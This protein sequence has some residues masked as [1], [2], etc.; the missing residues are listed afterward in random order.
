MI[1]PTS[2]LLHTVNSVSATRL[3]YIERPLTMQQARLAGRTVMEPDL[4]LNDF[5]CS[6]VI[7]W[8]EILVALDRPTQFQW[9][10]SAMGLVD[11]RK[12]FVKDI[13]DPVAPVKTLF[14][15]KIQEP[16]M[17]R[18]RS[19]LNAIE[20]RFGLAQAPILMAVEISIDF[21]PKA[22][23]DE[24]RR[25]LMGVLV[26]HHFPDQDVLTNMADR[27]RCSWGTGAKKTRFV[28]PLRAT[29]NLKINQYQLVSCEN[30]RPAFVD[31]TYYVGELDGPV[32]WR[33][34]DKVIDQQN[35]TAGTAVVLNEHERRVRVEVTL[36]TTELH[37]IGIE[38]F[39]DLVEANFLKLQGGFFRFMLPTFDGPNANLARKAMNADRHTKFLN[40]GVLGLLVM[41]DA[42][43]RDAKLR[44]RRLRDEL[45]KKR[46]TIKPEARP[47]VGSAGTLVAYAAMNKKIETALRHLGERV[48]SG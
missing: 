26:R 40:T 1:L 4:D 46:K 34:M 47:G 45:L 38:W 13:D 39:D 11:G 27:P 35:R 12:V 17:G 22:P 16:R 31:A 19:A 8:I 5:S 48:R 18:V 21:T 43:R 25:K 7:D 3:G 28:L 36:E 32:M 44:R 41:D 2:V 30:D 37:R 23:S 6:A 24:M 10:Q 9:V 42:I 33:I 29:R 14:R 20:R 15:F